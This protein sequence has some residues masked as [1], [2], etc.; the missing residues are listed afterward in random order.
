MNEKKKTISVIG[1][2]I[3]GLTT[4]LGFKL[5]GHEVIGVDI[6]KDKVDMINNGICPI[7][8]PGLIEA[9]RKVKIEATTDHAAAIKSDITFI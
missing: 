3:V 4:A 1:L 9:L 5:R 8:E 2:G 6:Q 7:Y